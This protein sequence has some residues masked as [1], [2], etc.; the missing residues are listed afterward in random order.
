M[1]CVVNAMTVRHFNQDNA[2]PIVYQ[3]SILILPT[4]N[5]LIVIKVV[6]NAMVLTKI[7]ALSA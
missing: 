6:P 2:L 1:R 3:L 7:N 4:V 5:V